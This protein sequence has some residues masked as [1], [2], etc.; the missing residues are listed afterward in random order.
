MTAPTL[1]LAGGPRSH[2]PQPRLAELA[3]TLP[4]CELVTI[5]V[6]HLVHSL[7]PDDVLARVVPFLTAAGA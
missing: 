1:L 2:L 7:A 5:P 3:A 4:S 6:G